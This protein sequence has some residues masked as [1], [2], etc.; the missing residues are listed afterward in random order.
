MTEPEKP[1]ETG[2]RAETGRLAGEAEAPAGAG[3]AW[4]MLSFNAIVM[5]VVAL[6]FASGPYSSVGQELGYRYG[7]LAFLTSGALLPA[8]ALI[9]APRRT[10]T[11]VDALIAWTVMAFFGFAYYVTIAG[12]GMM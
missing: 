7:S 6:S 9:F 1:P 2:P 5:G 8:A 11:M 10:Q 12:G 3:C 4:A